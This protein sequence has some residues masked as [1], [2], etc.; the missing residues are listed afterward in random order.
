MGNEIYSP[1]NHSRISGTALCSRVE[2]NCGGGGGGGYGGGGYGGGCVVV[3]GGGV[4]VLVVLV[5]TQHS[6]RF[7]QQEEVSFPH[8]RMSPFLNVSCVACISGNC[9]SPSG[10]LFYSYLRSGPEDPPPS[11]TRPHPPFPA[12]PPLGLHQWLAR[13]ALISPGLAQRK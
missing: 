9:F 8:L 13:R 1:W 10:A 6:Q 5:S 3:A 2:V 7:P 11:L 12:A 4:T